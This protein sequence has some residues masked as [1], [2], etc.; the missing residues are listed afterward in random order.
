MTFRYPLCIAP[1][2][3][4]AHSNFLIALAPG[5][6]I[7]LSGK[8]AAFVVNIGIPVSITWSNVILLSVLAV[9]FLGGLLIPLFPGRTARIAANEASRKGLQ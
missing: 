1:R 3:M 7:D 8:P 4:T 2:K 6:I 5:G 9:V